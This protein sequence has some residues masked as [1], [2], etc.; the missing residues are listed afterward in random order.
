MKKGSLWLPLCFGARGDSGDL[1][2]NAVA[3]CFDMVAFIDID[4][5]RLEAL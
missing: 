5:I 2:G 3:A 1:H 4:Q